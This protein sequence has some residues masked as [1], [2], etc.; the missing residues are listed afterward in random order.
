MIQI[1]FRSLRNPRKKFPDQWRGKIL[2]IG[3]GG[4]EA[5]GGNKMQLNQQMIREYCDPSPEKGKRNR[6][7]EK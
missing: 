5:G 3:V 6:Y 1:F 7:A 2:I 4:V